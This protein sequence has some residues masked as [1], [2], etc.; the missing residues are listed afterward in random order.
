MIKKPIL[1][2]IALLLPVSIFLFLHYF[3]QNK[4]EIQVY[5][6]TPPANIPEDC[7][8][9]YE[10]PYKVLNTRVELSGPTIIFFTSGLSENLLDDS[11]FQLAR[12]VDEFETRTPKVVMLGMGKGFVAA[13]VNLVMDSAA[14]E[15]EKKCVFLAGSNRLVLIDAEKQIRGYYESATLKEVDRLIL[16]LKILFNDY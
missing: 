4:F 12:V 6:K 16:E 3:G 10:Y 15:I 1:L 11:K 13:G 14:Y 7:E 2:F 8:F 9:D 5:Y